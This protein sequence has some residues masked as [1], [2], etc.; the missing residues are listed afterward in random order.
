MQLK[1]ELFLDAI[2]PEHREVND[3]AYFLRRFIGN[4]LF[5]F[6]RNRNLGNLIGKGYTVKSAVQSYEHGCRRVL[7][8][9][10]NYEIAYEK[11]LNANHQH[12]FQYFMK[13]KMPKNNLKN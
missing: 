9:S 1:M 3:S 2:Y 12:S 11:K 4:G 10:W 13:E 7:R 6:S 5:A 8:H